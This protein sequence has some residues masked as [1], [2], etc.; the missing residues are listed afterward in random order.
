MG[1]TQW[2]TD[3]IGKKL[4]AGQKQPVTLTPSEM[5]RLGVNST[6]KDMAVKGREKMKRREKQKFRAEAGATSVMKAES[7]KTLKR[8][9]E[10]DDD[11]RENKTCR[12]L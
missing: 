7:S 6:S 4:P 11:D 8:K 10:S 2:W 3:V 5:E 9:I 1:C 12:K